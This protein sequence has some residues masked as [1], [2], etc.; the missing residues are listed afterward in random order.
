VAKWRRYR[1]TRRAALREIRAVGYDAAI[2][3]YEYFPNA[4]A[5]LWRAD[6][7]M[8][9][10]FTSAG[11]SAL[12]TDPVPWSDARAHTV[13]RQS[14]LLGRLAPGA[15]TVRPRYELSPT[16]A[17]AARRVDALL[18]Q[19]RLQPRGYVVV[20]IGAGSPEKAW[21]SAHWRAVTAQLAQQGE[22]LVFTG[23]GDAEHDSIRAVTRGLP[24]CVD[25]CD[26]LAWSDYVQVIRLARQVLTVDTAAG[27]VA[28]AVGTPSVT[29]W[30]GIGSA[31][32]WRPLSE[33]SVVI[34]NATPAELLAAIGAVGSSADRRPESS[35]RPPSAGVIDGATARTA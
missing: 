16:P 15:A 29:V 23:R 10:G 30:S 1:A 27:H 32:H 26:R 22:R 18:A 25:L 20:H 21:P 35:E 31:T 33:R 19:E 28:A 4:A 12:Y 24:A 9:I 34:A 14:A 13:D 17:D 6:I 3:L 5:L 2:D 7:P 8:R 11:F